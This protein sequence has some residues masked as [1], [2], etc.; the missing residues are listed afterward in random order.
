MGVLG[1]IITWAPSVGFNWWFL[2]AAILASAGLLWPGWW[3]R[4]LAIFLVIWLRS[5]L[6]I[7]YWR[8]KE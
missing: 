3:G 2:C 6:N 1:S 7:S 5:E 4:G 8:G